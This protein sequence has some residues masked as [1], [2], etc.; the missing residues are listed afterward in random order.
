MMN[1]QFDAEGFFKELTKKN[2]L[3]TSLGFAFGS[4]SGID[5]FYDAVAQNNSAPNIIVIDDSSEGYLSLVNSPFARS[6]KTLFLSMRH[7]ASDQNARNFALEQMRE[8]FR[9]F[10][11]VLIRERTK[12]EEQGIYID[13]RIQFNEID[14]YFCTG[15]ACAYFQIAVDVPQS[16]CFNPQ[17]WTDGK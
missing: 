9:Q 12:L 10:M 4:C 13:Q 5:G 2:K 17:E 7:K 8:I 16:L 6:V 14:S 15:A 3:A 1:F 11:S